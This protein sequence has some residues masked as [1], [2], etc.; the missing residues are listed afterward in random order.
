MSRWNDQRDCRLAK[1]VTVIMNPVCNNRLNVAAAFCNRTDQCIKNMVAFISFDYMDAAG[2]IDPDTGQPFRANA[3]YMQDESC[4][5]ESISESQDCL[6]NV[7]PNI[8]CG[9][10]FRAGSSESESQHGYSNKLPTP[11]TIGG[12]YPHFYAIW[13]KVN[14]GGMGSTSF[15]LSFPNSDPD[16]LVEMIVDFYA[17][18]VDIS[19]SIGPQESPIPGYEFGRGPM[20]EEALSYRIAPIRKASSGLIQDPCC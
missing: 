3:V 17:I 5:E 18:P 9:T 1:P 7:A 12:T 16:D 11:Y 6:E 8:I 10:S 4:S 2:D 20:T 19:A 14:V 13:D 15:R